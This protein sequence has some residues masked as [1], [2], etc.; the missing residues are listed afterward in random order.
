LQRQFRQQ[1][2]DADESHFLD[3]LDELVRQGTTLAERL[4]AGWQGGR[5][6]KLALLVA[7]CGYGGNQYR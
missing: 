4:L 6:E 2:S 5:R 7:H 1:L 3:P